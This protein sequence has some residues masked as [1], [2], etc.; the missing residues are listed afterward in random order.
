MRFHGIEM[1]G[2]FINQKVADESAL[3]HSASDEGR[4]IYDE[5]TE[6]MFFASSSD[7]VQLISS[8][9]VITEIPSNSII[10]FESNTQITGWTL[11][12]DQ[13]DDVVYITKG[14]V[15]GG[16]TG[17][18]AKSGG[19]YTY[20]HN[21]TYTNSTGTHNHKYYQASGNGYTWDPDGVTQ[22][23]MDS[24]HA[25]SQNG[26]QI[27]ASDDEGLTRD[28]YTQNQTISISG[29]VDADAGNLALGTWRPKGRNFTRQQKN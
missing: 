22:Y 27:E 1:V 24:Y 13:D 5:A 14:S 2:K 21:H 11:L 7:W 6:E 15:A 16:E 4:A 18:T 12:T 10:L 19:T 29:T 23:Y 9:N 8:T 28:A 3:V 17:G 25:S 26:F 20:S